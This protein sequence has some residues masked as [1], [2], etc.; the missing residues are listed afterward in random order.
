[1]DDD[2]KTTMVGVASSSSSSSSSQTGEL[3]GIF[4][5]IFQCSS[6]VGGSIS[7]LYYGRD[8]DDHRPR[9]SIAL[10]VL[11]LIFIVIGALSTRLLLPPSMLRGRRR[12]GEDS[13]TTRGTNSTNVDGYNDEGD[14]IEMITD[15]RSPLAAYVS[16]RSTSDEKRERT[17]D[18][19]K[20]VSGDDD[21]SRDTWTVEAMGTLR[22]FLTSEMMCMSPLFFYTVSTYPYCE[23][24]SRALPFTV[25]NVTMI[26]TNQPDHT[27]ALAQRPSTVSL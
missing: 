12:D 22:L 2:G 25:T 11:F 19:I 5:A 9:G 24:C 14:D 1:V 8:I 26:L 20:S 13:P 16:D 23:E 3:M 17:T 4:W 18:D 10:Y 27:S 15:E 6:I 7:L 21:L